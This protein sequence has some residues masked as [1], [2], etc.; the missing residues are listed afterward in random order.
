METASLKKITSIAS[1]SSAKMREL[2]SPVKRILTFSLADRIIYPQRA[3]CVSI[4]KNLL[5]IAYGSSFLSKSRIH[6]HKTYVFEDRYPQPAELASSAVLAASQLGTAKKD[7]TL[8]IP[9][10]WAVMRTAEFPS[11]IKENIPNAISYELDRLTPFGPEEAVYDFRVLREINGKLVILVVAAKADLISSYVDALKEKGFNVERITIN[12]SGIGSFLRYFK[13]EETIFAEVGE[14]GYE[15]AVISGGITDAFSGAFGDEDAKSRADT[16]L[17]D[18]EPVLEDSRKQGKSP[19]VFVSLK[20]RDPA[21]RETLKLKNPS[22]RIMDETGMKLQG[23][24]EADIS[25]PAAGGLLES[26]ST[27]PGTLNLLRKGARQRIKT[28]VGFTLALLALVLIIGIIYMISPLQV[29]NKRLDDIDRQIAAKK[30]EVRKVEALQKEIGALKKEVAAVGYFKT[31]APMTL[32]LLKELTSVLPKTTWLTRTRI[33]DSTVEI[34]GYA[35]AATELLPKL[36]ASKYFEKVEFS[37]PTFRDARMKA[38]RFIIKMNIEG[39]KEGK[40]EGA[41]GEVK[42]EEK[43]E[44]KG[45]VKGE[46]K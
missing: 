4:E 10:A 22:I 45:A 13:K 32:D 6:G 46:K 26:L 18:I 8:S 19:Q 7:I 44:T 3:L 24:G 36:E 29:E 40:D 1:G 2:L 23:A 33:T 14:S 39:I 15:G 25:Y 41:K 5:T 37:S 42:G 16:I 34:E 43:G 27:D 30:E 31:K 12:L 11:A 9:K 17:R 35:S 21:L 38:D 20:D 28:P